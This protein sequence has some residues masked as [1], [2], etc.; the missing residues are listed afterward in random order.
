MKLSSRL[1]FG[2]IICAFGFSENCIAETNLPSSGSNTIT[3]K[4][5]PFTLDRV[6]FQ[7]SV[8]PPDFVVGVEKILKGT[9]NYRTSVGTS[10]NFSVGTL[11]SMSATSSASSTPDYGLFSNASFD[12][13]D[14]STIQ[15]ASGSLQIAEIKQSNDNGGTESSSEITTITSY[16]GFRSIP[17]DLAPAEWVVV[18]TGGSSSGSISGTFSKTFSENGDTSN[19]V[20]VDGVGTSTDINLGDT[21]SFNT[22][23]RKVGSFLPSLNGG[24]SSIGGRVFDSAGTANGS[25]NGSV[26]TS[27]S[28]TASNSQ[29]V[30]SFIQ[31][32]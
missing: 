21:A 13:A 15:Q 2:L 16:A 14:T 26:N 10:D 31:A 20:T 7:L 25:A 11:S 8:A 18:T 28:A 23:A 32:Y 17:P 22:H 3:S 27:T 30:S 19:D 24:V 5:G 29:F 6:S 4:P 9:L 12:V 1:V